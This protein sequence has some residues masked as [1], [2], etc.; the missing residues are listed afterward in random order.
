MLESKVEITKRLQTEGRWD[1]ASRHRDEVRQKFRTEGATRA[2]AN[3]RAWEAMAEKYP[4]NRDPQE[5][6][7]GHHEGEPGETNALPADVGAGADFS[8]DVQWVYMN[9]HSVVI[10]DGGG[11]PRCD[12]SRAA[13]PPPG[14]GAV[15]LMAWAADNRTGFFKDLLPKIVN[16]DEADE[17]DLVRQE[18]KSIA[19]IKSVLNRMNEGFQR[20]MVEDAPAAVKEAVCSSLSDWKRS[21]GATLPA[22]ALF[23]LDAA[24]MRLGTRLVAASSAV[25]DV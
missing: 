3:E 4:P 1:E 9:Y 25:A 8:A 12:F 24:V 7:D 6:V 15:G 10:A 13:S 14:S 20:Q 18:K 17:E 22:E 23:S 5:P 16:T 2:E 19:E 11:R 21:H